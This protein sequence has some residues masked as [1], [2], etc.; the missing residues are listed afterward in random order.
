LTYDFERLEILGDSVL[1]LLASIDV[2]LRN[3]TTGEGKLSSKRQDIICNATLY[4]VAT[5]LEI[6]RYSRLTPFFAKLWCPPDL[7]KQFDD[8]ILEGHPYIDFIF[9]EGQQRWKL[10]W[11]ADERAGKRSA[12]HYLLPNGD[13]ID[14]GKDGNHV[15][16]SGA[17]RHLRHKTAPS[18]TPVL[19]RFGHAIPPKCLADLIESIIGAV[20][21]AGGYEGTIGL[22]RGFGIM[23]DKM[24]NYRNIE[25]LDALG[26][27]VGDSSRNTIPILP[28][29][30]KILV[31]SISTSSKYSNFEAYTPNEDSY[32]FEEVETIL[33]YKFKCRRLLFVA[34]T[35]SSVDVTN[36]NERLEWLGD[37]VLDWIITKYY[38]ENYK[39]EKMMTPAL[40]TSCRQAAVCNEA[41]SRIAV[42][43]GLHKYLRID[44]SFLQQE[45]AQYVQ[46]VMD[47][48]MGSD[49]EDPEGPL[50]ALSW[51]T[52]Y[53]T[54]FDNPDSNPID[55]SSTASPSNGQQHA[56]RPKLT[57]PPAPKAIGDLFEGIA[58]AVIIDLQFDI[59]AF[60]QIYMPLIRWYLD[61]HA[62]PYDLPENPISD[63]WHDYLAAGVPPSAIEFRYCQPEEVQQRLLQEQQEGITQVR[64][65][66]RAS[67]ATCQVLVRG[68]VVSEATAPNRELARKFATRQA[69]IYIR[70]SGWKDFLS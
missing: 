41:F 51:N 49:A 15:V 53:S 35:H 38:Y 6:Y 45:I 60:T 7:R 33:G 59:E 10:I 19:T 27:I 63:F 67:T 11:A 69:V 5:S 55:S 57:I 68:R 64:L 65:P 17:A 26:S 37:A 18:S 25:P 2:F 52:K 44:G 29:Q 32:P 16:L 24:L 58:G 50:T 22:L 28:T 23:S 39:D 13:L 4:K 9:D 62:D 34:M 61:R 66:E 8:G 43:Y 54:S 46:A 48:E 70:T 36:S 3:P 30:P 47:V 12:L 20:F 31:P 21:F 56:K 14:K 1:K 42:H 40:I